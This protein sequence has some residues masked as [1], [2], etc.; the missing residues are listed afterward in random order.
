MLNKA[1][2]PAG[3][4][5]GLPDLQTVR[6]SA[7]TEAGMD[8]LWA[9]LSGRVKALTGGDFPAVT[10]LRHRRHLQDAAQALRRGQAAL[11]RSPELGA[12]DLRHAAQALGR[13]AGRIDPEQVLDEVFSSFC[14]GK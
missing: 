3:P 2:L 4:D 5:A 10:R 9:A 11:A 7:K 12:E 1:D 6:V 8:A 13:I 14:I